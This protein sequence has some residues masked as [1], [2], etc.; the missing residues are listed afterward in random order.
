MA[1]HAAENKINIEIK[2]P[3]NT[4]KLG[5]SDLIITPIGFGA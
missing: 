1:C 4:R 2:E 3:M 5:T